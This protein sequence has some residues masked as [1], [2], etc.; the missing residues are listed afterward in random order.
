MKKAI[1]VTLIQPDL[2]W[3]KIETNLI[4][5]TEMV[6][7]APLGSDLILL[8][9]TFATGFTM[10]ADRFAEAMDGKAVSWMKQI[11]S[12]RGCTIAGS[13][14]IRDQNRIY[15]RLLWI[16]PDG[17]EGTYDKRHLFRMGR[18]DEH[19]VPGNERPV[20]TLGGYR[21]LPQICYDLRFPV[22]SRN[23]GDY[24]V[25]VYVANWPAPRQMVWDSL[26]KAR[27]IENQAYVLAVSRVGTDG[28]GVDHVGGTC[29]YDPM[30]NPIQILNDQE[31]ILT[32]T[33]EL[34]KLKEF[35]EKFP[36]WKDADEF[37]IKGV[38]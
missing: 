15:N 16:T 23:R 19:F 2:V 9:E 8:P 14:I 6:G 32:A 1:K 18:E 4:R 34:E 5:L 17:I 35:R 21:F 11:A 29:V 24:D 33:L 31:G 30:G 10:E 25:L 36:A 20:F 13:L 38:D 7:R 12:E 26:T 22:F 27:A 37:S 3:E 28:V